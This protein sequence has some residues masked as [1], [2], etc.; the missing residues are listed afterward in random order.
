M[1]NTTT[2]QCYCVVLSF[3][4]YLDLFDER[5][6]QMYSIAVYYMTANGVAVAMMVGAAGVRFNKIQITYV[7]L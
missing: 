6:K 1:H 5:V 7:S 3:G 2:R 4:K